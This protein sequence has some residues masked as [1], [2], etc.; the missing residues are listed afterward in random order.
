M[1]SAY[2]YVEARPDMQT[3]AEL[4]LLAAD[5]PAAAFDTVT[6]AA[7]LL[8]MAIAVTIPIEPTVPMLEIGAEELPET[9]G[10]TE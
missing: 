1:R 4:R 9:T 8:L 7:E 2:H 3:Q 10:N 5:D 6:S